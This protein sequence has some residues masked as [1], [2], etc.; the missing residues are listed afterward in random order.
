MDKLIDLNYKEEQVAFTLDEKKYADLFPGFFNY[1]LKDAAT[2]LINR[3]KAYRENSQLDLYS[4]ID[5]ILG[6]L[7]NKL[8]TLC[9]KTLILD[10]HLYKNSHLLVGDT[11]QKRYE[12]FANVISQREDYIIELLNDYTIL[13]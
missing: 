5:G 9:F 7:S 13:N 1:F 11:K 10:L 3:T 6:G 2:K 4:I 8:Q 12:Y